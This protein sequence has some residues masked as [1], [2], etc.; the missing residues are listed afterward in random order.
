MQNSK[1]KMWNVKCKMQNAKYEGGKEEV[2]FHRDNIVWMEKPRLFHWKGV[3]KKTVYPIK[4][5]SQRK[6][7]I[8]YEFFPIGGG[9]DF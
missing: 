2:V 3:A 8:K 9:G 4:E 7:R 6:N 5:Q 1:C